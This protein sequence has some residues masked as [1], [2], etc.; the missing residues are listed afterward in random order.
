M[1]DVLGETVSGVNQARTSFSQMNQREQQHALKRDP[2]SKSN[3]AE[4]WGKTS[5]D[6][7]H[8]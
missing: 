8:F 5:I 3:S 1:V 7:G 6:L 4:T 2:F